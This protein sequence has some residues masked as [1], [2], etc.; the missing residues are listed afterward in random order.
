MTIVQIYEY[1]LSILMICLC[2]LDSSKLT[3][4]Y[5]RNVIVD[6]WNWQ[7]SKFTPL[8][9]NIGTLEW[10]V[11]QINL[12]TMYFWTVG[13]DS[14]PNLQL[15]NLIFT[16]QIM[17]FEPKSLHIIH[18]ISNRFFQ[19]FSDIID[20]VHQNSPF[21]HFRS[22]NTDS[23]GLIGIQEGQYGFKRANT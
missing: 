14:P 19:C 9:L 13:L 6:R 8:Q 5:C 23:G 2:N 4:P 11:V 10:M 22:A 21:M 3:T 12:C 16:V 20:R 1:I 17:W 7:S 15:Y 18:S